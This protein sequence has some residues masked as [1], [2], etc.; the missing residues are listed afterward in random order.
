VVVIGVSLGWKR[1]EK[2]EEPRSPGE[3]F[4]NV[5]VEEVEG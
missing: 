1:M 5:E 4:V 3:F 2:E